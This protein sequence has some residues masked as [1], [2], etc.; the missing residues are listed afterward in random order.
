M[1]KHSCGLITRGVSGIIWHVS[2][3]IN[4]V[5]MISMHEANTHFEVQILYY[6]ALLIG[7]ERSSKKDKIWIGKSEVK[8]K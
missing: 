2:V 3:V 4:G 8:I 5:I 7:Q 1:A 6:T